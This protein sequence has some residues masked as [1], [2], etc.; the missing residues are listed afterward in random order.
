MKWRG[1]DG[2]VRN[3]VPVDFN[4]SLCQCLYCAHANPWLSILC[5]AW[6]NQ[7]GF[8][9]VHMPHHAEEGIERVHTME[10]PP[11]PRLNLL[12]CQIYQDSLGLSISS[13]RM[14]T[15]FPTKS[16]LFRSSEWT[17]KMNGADAIHANHARVEC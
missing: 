11:G 12:V 2:L 1:E 17:A 6:M 14:D 7:G 3:L 13:Q 8:S 16:A 10:K 5:I 4:F 9:P 15:H